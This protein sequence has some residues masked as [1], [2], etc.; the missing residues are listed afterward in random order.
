MDT[1]YQSVLRFLNEAGAPEDLVKQA[2]L[3]A[4]TAASVF[5]ARSAAGGMFTSADQIAAVLSQKQI[6]Q[7]VDL[8]PRLPSPNPAL[9]AER[10]NFVSLVSENPNYFGTFVDSP[11]K[12]V[13]AFNSNTTYE[14]LVC[15]GLQPQMDRL[16]AVINIKRSNGYGGDICSNGSHEYV[17][18]FVDL[19]DNG[20]FHDVGVA[21]VNVH[22]LPGV[23]PLCYAVYLDFTS[24]KKFC[25]V[26]NVVKVR[27]VLSWNAIPS[28][29]P[30]VLP[31]WGNRVDAEVQ[32]RP[33][34]FIILGD[35]VKDLELAKVKLPDPV[36]PV[37]AGLDPQTKIPI[38]PP[39]PLTLA[40]KRKVYAR[41]DVP[42]HRFAFAELQPLINAAS[43]PPDVFTH[44]KSSV[45]SNLGLVATEVPGLFDNLKVKADGDTSFEQLACI[46][47]RP[48]SSALEGVLT[49]KKPLGYSGS[50][51]GQGSTEFVAFFAD[52]SDGTGFHHLA[53][54]SVN[55]HD[56]NAV[57]A[58][59]VQ[60]AVFAK[61]NFAKWRVPCEVGARIGRLRAILSWEVAPPANNP[62]YIP[63]WGNR[64]ECRFQIHPGV[65]G[66][67]APL[68]ETVGDVPVNRINQGTGR[69]TGALEI[70]SAT[71]N[72]SPFGGEV[73][74]TGSL[75]LPPDSFG[76]GALPFKYRIEVKRD[77]GVD[78]YHPLL[79]DVQV[80]YTERN[81]GAPIFCSFFEFVCQKTLHPT[82]DVDGLGDGWYEYIEDATLPLT[83][84]LITNTLGRWQ[85]T[86]A[87]EGR[88]KLRL[89]AKNP[90]VS[91]P[92]VFNGVQEVVV[93]VDNTAP[94]ASVTITGA[95][96]NG[97][98]VAAV[99]CG[100][101]PVGTII[102]G[103]YTATDPGTV[104]PG[105]P[106]F[107]HFGGLT[108]EV[109]P[110]DVAN[111]AAVSAL[112]GGPSR[113]FPVVP[114]TGENGTWTLDTAG[115]DPCGYVIRLTVCD[116][117]NRDSRGIP[118][119]P[120]DDVGFCLE[121]VAPPTR[122]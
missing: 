71:V 118:F 44:V 58:G 102:S 69:A 120:T 23:K 43:A 18:F 6:L 82:N 101:F 90:N 42:V 86:A 11:F 38:A 77:D 81:N 100:K 45:L 19:H 113:S 62:N 51:C 27:A 98:T 26:S 21:A 49:V 20:V 89:T 67:H 80:S 92:T 111:G 115:M 29:N 74:I 1:Q 91:P 61:A 8:A 119:C 122:T 25:T 48:G 2:Q 110:A 55:V 93:R 117:T 52:F 108:F 121:A 104:A 79:N 33:R 47:V 54:T 24:V 78:T 39:S 64:L 72:Q 84:D 106:E 105:D 112:G 30:N 28:T 73:T 34:S 40:Q 37:V 56:L 12:P 107:A 114:T 97:T 57:P 46:G 17:R 3:P 5:F 15:V 95:T 14:E 99:G 103:N 85:T 76:G 16:E 60:Y 70:A 35:L 63:L 83:R 53:T 13:K 87:M 65:S 50:L 88:W 59:G 109:I 31:V 75:G 36:G 4:D 66:S 9:E 22:D 7:I 94:V 68:I 41:A 10:A 32:V 116:R 96:F